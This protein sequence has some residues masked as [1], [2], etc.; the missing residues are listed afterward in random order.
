MS[1]DA[2]MI[3]EVAVRLQR[4]KSPARFARDLKA[5]LKGEEERDKAGPPSFDTMDRW[6]EFY[7]NLGVPLLGLPTEAQKE[8]LHEFGLRPIFMPF[9]GED[10]YPSDFVK[11]NWGQYLTASEIV[12]HQLPGRLVAVESIL[13]PNYTDPAGYPN[14]KLG[15]ALGLKT[16][17]GVSYDDLQG[18]ILAKAAKV[19][20]LPEAQVRLPYAEEWNFAANIFKHLRDKYGENLPDLGATDSWEWCENACGSGFRLIAGYRAHGGLSAVD[21]G[22][23]DRRDGDLG[24]RVL[25]V[26]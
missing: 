19:L 4:G 11:P 5:L 26:L 10:Q 21:G 6:A 1:K 3:E 23:H 18:G 13:K 16:R 20:G 14:D 24:F 9:V 25:A 2:A 8:A 15:Q 12:R 22:W 17:F 7:D